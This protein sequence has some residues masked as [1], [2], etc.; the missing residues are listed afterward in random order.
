MERNSR[1]EGERA[2]QSIVHDVQQL[3]LWLS[4][5][6]LPLSVQLDLLPTHREAAVLV[7]LYPR[8]DVI[9]LL[10]TRKPD[11]LGMHG[12]QIALPGG[13][14]DPTDET[15]LATALREAWEEVGIPP[16]TIQLLGRL[17]PIIVRVS[18]FQVVPFVGW[19]VQ[20]PTI[21]PNPA[22]VE[23]VLELPLSVLLD[24]SSVALETWELRGMRWRVSLYDYHGHKIW[25]ATARVLSQLA[26]KL[27]ASSTLPLVPGSVEHLPL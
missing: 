27:G 11:A 23:A 21:A 20:L 10:L 22:E 19:S 7:L 25:G 26:E 2:D 6:L 14:R 5:R 1:F 9:Y 3:P 13:A 24:P 4:Q 15:L 18:S 12:G 8:G 17:D 16:R